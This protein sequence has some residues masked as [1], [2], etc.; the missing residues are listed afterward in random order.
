M[1]TCDGVL[2]EQGQA[3]INFS[4]QESNVQHFRD[5]FD[6]RLNVLFS[7]VTLNI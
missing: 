6:S 3:S 7:D 2:Y 4:N 1:R 5:T